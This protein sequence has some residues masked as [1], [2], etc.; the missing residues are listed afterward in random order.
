[1][2]KKKRIIPLDFYPVARQPPLRSLDAKI[3]QQPEPSPTM[4]YLPILLV[5]LLVA[6][7]GGSSPEPAPEV[8]VGSTPAASAGA[9]RGEASWY[10]GKYHGRDTAS[11]EKFDKNAMTAAHRDLPFGTRVRVTNLENGKSVVVRVNDRYMG[12]KR[13]IDLS[14]AAFAQLAPT[15][16]G[17]IP[18]QVEV[19]K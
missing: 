8:R 1:V 7:S 16:R 18:V 17:V 11:G 4:R 10:G 3:I 12:G 5:I 2:A 9:Q 6:C 19:I 13:V 14:E 15:A